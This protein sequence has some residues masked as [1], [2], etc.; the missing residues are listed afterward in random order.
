MIHLKKSELNNEQIKLLE[1]NNFSSI[2]ANP[3][4]GTKQPYDEYEVVDRVTIYTH[5]YYIDGTRYIADPKVNEGIAK[6]KKPMEIEI[7]EFFKDNNK[8]N[9]YKVA[10]TPLSVTADTGLII[11]GV[12]AAIIYAPFFLTYMAYE[13]IKGK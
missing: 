4:Y 10:M 11:I 1:K 13:E 8:S 12:G 9:F 2:Q 5:E 7:I 6:L 3:N